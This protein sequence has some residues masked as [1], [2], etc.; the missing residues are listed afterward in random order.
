MLN[1]FILLYADDTIIMADNEHDKQRNIDPLNEY[2]ICNK[3]RVNISKT[4]MMVFP[5]SKTRIRNIR[6]FKFGYMDLDHVD[7]YIYLGICFNWNGS[8][9]KT[10]KLL[11]DKASKAM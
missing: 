2:C 9:V 11:H 4:K 6:T 8:F 1:L 5:R 3:L 10:K 7:D